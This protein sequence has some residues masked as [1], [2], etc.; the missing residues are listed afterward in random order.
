[1]TYRSWP[2]LF[3]MSPGPTGP[4]EFTSSTTSPPSRSRSERTGRIVTD[5]LGWVGRL[6]VPVVA[7]MAVGWPRSKRSPMQTVDPDPNCWVPVRRLKKKNFEKK[8]LNFVS[9]CVKVKFGS[10]FQIRTATS[11]VYSIF[12]PASSQSTRSH[13]LNSATSSCYCVCRAPLLQ[14]LVQLCASVGGLVATAHIV[15]NLLTLLVN[16]LCCQTPVLEAAAAAEPAADRVGLMGAAAAGLPAKLAKL[17]PVRSGPP[18]KISW[19]V[20]VFTPAFFPLCTIPYAVWFVCC[21]TF[22]V[23]ELIWFLFVFL[24]A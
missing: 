1:M 18:V 6:W 7:E 9:F 21:R 10:E 12:V 22:L 20:M 23:C 13:I 24:L 8:N 14:F 3:L 5:I 17:S 15:S 2:D 19:H 16:A 4:P 11:V